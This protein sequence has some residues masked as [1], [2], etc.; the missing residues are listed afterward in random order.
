[1][2]RAGVRR[3]ERRDGGRGRR[4]VSIRRARRLQSARSPRMIASHARSA[5]PWVTMR[6]VSD[7]AGSVASVVS[8]SIR[9]APRNRRTN[10]SRNPA[11]RKPT[12]SARSSMRRLPR[13]SQT[14]STAN[15]IAT[16][17]SQFARAWRMRA[18]VC[19]VSSWSELTIA[20]RPVDSGSCSA[21]RPM[22]A[23][24]SPRSMM[25]GRR[26][27]T[28]SPPVVE[29]NSPSSSRSSTSWRCVAV[30]TRTHASCRRG[31]SRSRFAASSAPCRVIPASTGASAFCASGRRSAS[32]CSTSTFAY[33]C[34]TA[35]AAT[36]ARMSS[37][38]I[39]SVAIV[40]NPSS[41]RTVRSR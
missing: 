10:S 9:Y 33:S 1:M 17:Q 6:H 11:I 26:S 14:A 39:S 22:I 18:P 40:S 29:T 38:R 4:A 24:S 30:A 8:E 7:P 5:R 13:A 23:T 21:I 32:A 37:E 31:R 34:S 2:S 36:C 25:M 41:S 20:I 27:S 19:A 16:S 3:R 28:T 15:A 35:V 12:A